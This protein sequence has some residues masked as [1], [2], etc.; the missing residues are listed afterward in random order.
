MVGIGRTPTTSVVGV[1]A[2]TISFR[3]FPQGQGQGK[4][5]DKFPQGQLAVAALTKTNL[6]VEMWASATL[7]V[8]PPVITAVHQP[9]FPIL[10]EG[11]QWATFRLTRMLTSMKA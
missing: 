7:L 5:Q 2:R 11:P 4:F 3:K 10:H 9:N 1:S 8:R 6:L